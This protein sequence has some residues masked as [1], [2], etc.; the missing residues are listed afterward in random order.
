M[1]K[2]NINTCDRKQLWVFTYDA[3]TKKSG[4]EWNYS[5]FSYTTLIYLSL[6]L[7]RTPQKTPLLHGRLFAPLFL[8]NALFHTKVKVKK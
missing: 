4:N 5:Y 1:K 2:S 3:L 6:N 8:L 7:V